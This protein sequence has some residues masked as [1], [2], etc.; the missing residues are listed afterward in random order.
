MEE[1]FILIKMTPANPTRHPIIL[2]FVSFSILKRRDGIKIAIKVLE[3][4]II[5]LFTP[6]VLA[7]PM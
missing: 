6:D 5:E 2:F 4:L 7:S 1:P 3:A